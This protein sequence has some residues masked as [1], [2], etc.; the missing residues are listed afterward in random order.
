MREIVGELAKQSQWDKAVEIANGIEH[1]WAR[2]NALNDITI[3]M[4][5]YNQWDKAVEIA[6]RIEDNGVKAS[7]L[8]TVIG[9][10]AEL[11]PSQTSGLLS[12]VV[13][14]VHRIEDNG[15]RS[16]VLKDVAIVM[17]KQNQWDKA[18][19]VAS[20]IEDSG[21]RANAFK[22]IALEFVQT[23]MY[24]EQL[25]FLTQ[26]SWRQTTTLNEIL[27]LLPMAVP[28]VINETPILNDLTKDGFNWVSNFK[29]SS[30]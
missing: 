6:S 14:L 17:A 13:E 9:E 22:D 2:A 15:A 23:D 16:A 21:A 11:E 7:A 10:L 12:E 25:L 8:S 28:L 24:Q 18:V 27:A 30:S 1:N 29:V 4:A 3:I 26:Q 19:E 20:G 5:K